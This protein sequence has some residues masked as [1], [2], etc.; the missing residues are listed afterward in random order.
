MNQGNGSGNGEMLDVGDFKEVE[1]TG[2][3]NRLD[4][5]SNLPFTNFTDLTGLSTHTIPTSVRLYCSFSNFYLT[6]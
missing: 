4:F 5:N 6:F 1:T 3:N 2:A